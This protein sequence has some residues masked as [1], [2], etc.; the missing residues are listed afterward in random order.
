MEIKFSK[1]YI[2]SLFITIF[3]LFFLA[4]GTSYAILKGNSMSNNIQ[5]VKAGS[6]E[7]ELNEKYD[8]LETGFSI[9]K[10]TQGLQQETVYEFTI[11]NIGS[12]PAK[13]DLKL[14]NTAPSGQTALSDEYIRIG[15]EVN[16]E[17]MGPMGLSNV[18]N[19]IDSNTI[20][21][22]EVI[23]YKMRVW[24]DKTKT[25]QI[26]ANN[27]KKAYLSLKVE[28]KQSEY[29]P[30]V[31]Y[32][33]NSTNIQI[34]NTLSTTNMVTD[35]TELNKTY[36]LKYTMNSNEKLVSSEVCYVLNS[37]LYCLKGY[38]GN[39]TGDSPYYDSNVEIL[40]ESFPTNTCSSGATTYSCT[41]G[42]ITAEAKQDGNI[43]VYNSNISCY[44][45]AYGNSACSNIQ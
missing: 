10:D 21:N 30:R 33:F 37:D 12:A 26:Q 27:T 24:L 19:V 38:K 25:S 4:S 42:G 43:R 16:G 45:N 31:V 29:T 18:D 7:L 14:L 35:Y 9:M 22:D 36:F 32:G 41:S 17:E 15:L 23:R 5:V 39:G 20:N 40:K 13:Y 44:V 11:T 1:R 3:G 6:V 34:G 28:A 2:V 8:S